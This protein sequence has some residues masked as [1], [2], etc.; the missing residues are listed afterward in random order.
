M[1]HKKLIKSV[2]TVLL[3]VLFMAKS[4]VAQNH[5]AILANADSS[6]FSINKKDGWQLYNS[7]VTPYH[8]DSVQLE[9][10]IRQ[11][12]TIDWNAEQYVGKIKGAGLFPGTAQ[13]L[14]FYLIQ[15]EYALRV[16]T[17]GKCYLRLVK[18]N[19]AG[20]DPAMVPVQVFYK[21]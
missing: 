4:A 8:S 3:P 1:K 12:N 17:N 6:H 11:S 20:T 10:V 5:D 16:E 2:L 19:P 9:L 13:T 14:S 15:V 7:Y 18:G 21:K